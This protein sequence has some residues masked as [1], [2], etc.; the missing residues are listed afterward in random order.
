VHTPFS[1]RA[2]SWRRFFAL[3]AVLA[4]VLVACGGGDDDDNAGGGDNN[5]GGGGSTTQTT[6]GGEPV[7]GGTLTYAV[8]ADTASPW[9]PSAMVCAAACHS[10]VGRTVFEPLVELGDDGKTYPYLAQSVTPNDDFTVWTIVVRQGI[11]F[12]DGTD[13]N[14]DAVKLNLD[15][16][17]TSAL[18][19]GAVQPIQDIA[20]DG[21]MTVTVTMN[22]PWPAFPTYLNSQLGYMA[23]P[24]WLTAVDAD[25]NLATQPVGTGPFKFQSYEPGDN[26][27]FKAT[28]FDDYWRGDGPNSLTGEGLP[29]LDAVEIDFVPDSQARSQALESGDLDLIQ[30]NNGVEINDLQSKDGVEVT[31]L[32]TPFETETSY[33]LIN[34]SAQVNGEDNPFADI[35]VRRALAMA[36]DNQTLTDARTGGLF[37]PANGPFPPGV[38]GHLDDTGFPAYDPDGARELL[39][40]VQDE[41]GSPV[42]IHYKTTTDPF[43]LDTAELFQSMWEEVGFRVT[44]DQVP[45]GDFINQALGGNFEVFQWRNHSG[46]DPD[47]QFVWWSSTTTQGIALNFGRI[48]DDQ[49]DSLLDDIRTKTDPADRRQAAE[50]LNRRFGDQ[51]FNVWNTWVF[52]GFAYQDDVHQAS[53]LT[54]PDAPDG[55]TALPGSTVSPIM[56]YK[57]Q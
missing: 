28:R 57:D 35:R 31:V 32:D 2:S 39:Q 38:I 40:Q 41:T 54:I 49:V 8:E 6:E 10:T 45:Q 11:K 17:K 26:G 12:H 29:Y 27:S 53:L 19:Q 34:N 37:P 4:L 30:T 36:T 22:V 56:M 7:H 43:N 55:V 42:T 18:L 3:F 48:I 9:L 16:T 23:S 15:R 14:A 24:Q 13:L 46:N 44:I 33:L 5:N 1:R 20:S 52:W 47:N 25:P 21:N 50:D 51:V